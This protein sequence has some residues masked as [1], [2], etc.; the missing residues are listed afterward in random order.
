MTLYH[1]WCRYRFLEVY[2]GRFLVRQK[3]T[4]YIY[5][6]WYRWYKTLFFPLTQYRPHNSGA[7]TQ[8]QSLRDAQNFIWTRTDNFRCMKKMQRR[9]QGQ[10]P[11]TDVFTVVNSLKPSS[12]SWVHIHCLLWWRKS[13]F[14]VDDVTWL[15]PCVL[16]N[17]MTSVCL[18]CVRSLT[19]GDS[20]TK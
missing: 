7:V 13:K 9:V 16:R 12:H 10:F 11:H 19:K 3:G 8:F 6:S 2:I 17:T 18:S 5:Y 4:I 1:R 15:V 14:D 20:Q